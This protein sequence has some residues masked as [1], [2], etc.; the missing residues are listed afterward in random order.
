MDEYINFLKKYKIKNF[1][2]LITYHKKYIEKFKYNSMYGVYILNHVDEEF[3]FDENIF[4][5]KLQYIEFLIKGKELRNCEICGSILKFS[6]KKSFCKECKKMYYIKNK[7][8]IS[9]KRK[10]TCLKKY[11][12]EFPTRNKEI[13]NKIKSTNLEKYGCE[14]VL[15]N[16]TVHQ[17]TMK[18]NIKKY[19]NEIS[20]KSEYVKNKIKETFNLIK[21][22][23]IKFNCI[24]EKIKQTFIKKYNVENPMQLKEIKEKRK[25]T[26]LKKYGT[27]FVRNDE[28]LKE[29]NL[30]KYGFKN[31]KI[32]QAWININSLNDLIPLFKKEEFKGSNNLYK[33]QCKKCRN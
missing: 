15:Q 16:E 10:N 25:I 11:G 4:N 3:L 33:W 19:G 31:P 6:N 17:K 1:E 2:L 20:S 24:N 13:I 5:N 7:D 22:D 28:K 29:S 8:K 32:Y 27:E 26:M 30:K 18:T 14:C 23:N 21:N 9:E 12:C